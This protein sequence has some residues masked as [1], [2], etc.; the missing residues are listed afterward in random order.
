M[1]QHAGAD[2]GGAYAPVFLGE[3]SK[4]EKKKM[5]APL[6]RDKNVSQ[7]T[8]NAPDPSSSVGS[9]TCHYHLL[10]EYIS[11]PPFFRPRAL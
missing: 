5:F 7:N 2:G 9:T 4:F 8:E 10:L 6:L 1:A 11:R 3:K